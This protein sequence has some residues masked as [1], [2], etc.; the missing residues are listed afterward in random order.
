MF[1]DVGIMYRLAPHETVLEGHWLEADGRVVADDAEQ[2]ISHLLRESL[3]RLASR[4]DGW[5]ILFRDP[6]DGR[7]WELTYPHGEWHGG[8][9]RKLMCLA[10]DAARESY[11]DFQ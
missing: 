11:G 6:S 8:G 1:P 10:E 7:L 2:R 4:D 3:E 5:A 9:P